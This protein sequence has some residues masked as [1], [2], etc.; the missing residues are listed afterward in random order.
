MT[1]EKSMITDKL[2]WLKNSYITHRGYHCPKSAPENSMKAFTRALK[3]GFAIELDI[4]LTKDQ[5]VVVF[6]DDSLERM[7]GY[8]KNINL[9][10]WEEIK[11]LTLLDTQEKI[12]LLQ[13]VLSFIDGRVPLLI[14]IKNRGPVGDLESKTDEL[15]K[16]YQGDF[17]IQSF[18][19]YSVGWFKEHSPKIPRGQLSGMFK[20]EHLAYYK[21]FLLRNLML[22]HVSKPHF[23]NYDIEYLSHIPK[24]FQNKKRN[25]LLGYTAT[26]PTAYKKALEKTVNVV[27]EG[28]N[29]KEV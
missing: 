26:N 25:I 8:V 9:C 12:P 10:T 3:E 24:R 15:L 11:A 2:S 21:K 4:H 18:N 6:H 27:F 17:A 22:N 28:F 19:P 23:I 14:E 7:T 16:D 1:K 13:E 29:P 20:K 5:E